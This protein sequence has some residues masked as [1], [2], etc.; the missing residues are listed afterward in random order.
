MTITGLNTN[1]SNGVTV[2]S[3]SGTGITVNSTLVTSPTQAI[4]NITIAPDATLGARDVTA[5]T[6]T[7]IVTCTAAFTITV[8]NLGTLAVVTA[9]SETPQYG[10][11]AIKAVD[12]VIDGYP[13]DITREWVTAGEK[14]GAWLK[15]SWSTPYSVDRVVLYD[16]PNLGDNILSAT[17]TFS[18]GPSLEV[19][20]LN[21]NGTATEATF[22]PPG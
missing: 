3:F 10:Q 8:S 6:G 12:G 5:A 16:R 11:L 17:L 4:A 18:D 22:L 20:P 21:N 13:G 1:F 19:G 15:L 2:A 9:S 7:E 14:S